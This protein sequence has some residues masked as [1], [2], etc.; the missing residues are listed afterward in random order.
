MKVKINNQTDTD[1]ECLKKSFLHDV[2][3]T[4]TEVKKAFG[5]LL[6]DIFSVNKKF[7]G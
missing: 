2:K 7:Q 6:F 3:Q 1:N 5:F 4:E